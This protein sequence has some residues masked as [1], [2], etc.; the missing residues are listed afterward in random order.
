MIKRINIEEIE[1]EIIEEIE[2]NNTVTP[3]VWE[4]I[5]IIGSVSLLKTDTIKLIQTA[6]Q[7]KMEIRK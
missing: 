6:N 1:Q 2:D 5:N 7:L 4:L 3:R